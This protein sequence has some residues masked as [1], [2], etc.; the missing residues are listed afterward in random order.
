MLHVFCALCALCVCVLVNQSV[1]IRCEV[2]KKC[3]HGDGDGDDDEPS[4]MM[5]HSTR[6]VHSNLHQIRQTHHHRSQLN[7]RKE[8]QETRT[9][10]VNVRRETDKQRTYN[11]IKQDEIW[12]VCG[13]SRFYIDA[14]L[15]W[16]I[17]K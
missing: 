16:L 11:F 10:N 13:C 9:S 17:L 8:K 1:F 4:L 2:R 3:L 6:T 15:R 7:E 14:F 12:R 5:L